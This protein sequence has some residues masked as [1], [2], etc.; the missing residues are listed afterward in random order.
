MATAPVLALLVYDLI[1]FLG[2]LFQYKG[3]ERLQIS[4]LSV[5]FFCSGM[6]ALV[7]QIVWQRALFA[8]YGVNTESVAVVVSAFMLGLGLG[9]LAGGWISARWPRRAILFFGAAEL[10]VA[11]FG[12][13]SLRIFHWAAVYTAGVSLPLTV[14]FSLLLLSAPTMMMG[15]T[16]PLLVEHLVKQSGKVGFSV[17]TLYFVN[18]FGSAVACYLCATFLLRDFGKSGSVALAAGM[19]GLI[20]A[21]ALIIARGKQTEHP[22]NRSATPL[23]APVMEN[24]L[25]QRTAMLIAGLAGFIG[26]GF[27][28]AWFRTFV[29]ASSDRAPAFALLLSTNLAGIA[30]GSY[31]AGKLTLNKGS[32][33]VLSAVGLLMLS[34]GAISAYLPPF[35]AALKWKGVPF[36]LSAPAFF[37]TAALLG[38]VLPLLCQLGVPADERAG[39]GVSLIYVSNIGGSVLG[40][41]GVGFVLLEHLNLRQV[42][43]ALGAAAVMAGALVLCLRDGSWRIPTARSLA[44]LA[45]AT[46]LV[47]SASP[48]YG[49][50]FEK[51]IFASDP[52]EKTPFAHVLENRNGVIA[53]TPHGAV[54]GGGVY[55]GFFNVDP[56]NDVN[57]VIRAYALT[58]FHPAPKRMLMIGLSSGS[59]GQ[60]LANHPQVES[61]DIVEINPGY[62]QLIAQYPAVRSLL[63]N[64]KVRVYIDDGRRW[65]LA[66]PREQYDAVVQNTS[67]Y[68]RDHSSDLLSADYLRIIRLHLKPG[69]LYF[70]NTTS[71]DDVVA[72][73]LHVFP[74][75]LRVVNFLA[76]SDSPIAVDKERWTAILRRYQIDGQPV[77]DPKR[78]GMPETLARY[79]AFAD[80]VKQPPIAMGLETS[81]T[82]HGHL[83]RRLIITDDNMGWEWRDL[84]TTP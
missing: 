79:A 2:A 25:S 50:L 43:L 4:S 75:G 35:V 48:L 47:M 60:I 67:F 65:L 78:P 14:L 71:S 21:T 69:G 45:L 58:A 37:L 6:P 54:F 23:R 26:L 83:G 52:A 31:I 46:V 28:I 3:A 12:I 38:S 19:N 64:P 33:E 62:L 36:L 34:A 40:S 22:G 24:P 80:S 30:A 8:I 18:T 16:L 5:L 32:R 63:Q 73:G 7:Y 77:F 70:Y 27:E 15:A 61:L 41:L 84:P 49:G 51:L 59:W 11:L 53:V 81:Q 39:R 29:M 72:T 74:H 66:H 17:A 82:L 44:A 68:W 9:S 20:G 13:S 57:M 56:V 1:V 42:S 55:D 10:G 76:V